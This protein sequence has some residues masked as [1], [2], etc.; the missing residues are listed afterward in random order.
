MKK[1]LLNAAVV[2]ALGLSITACEKDE[3]RVVI[4]PSAMPALTVSNNA[5]GALTRANANDPGVTFSWSPAEFGY[6]AAVTYSLEIDKA[7]NNFASPRVFPMGNDRSKAFTKGELNQIYNDLDC[8][9]P[10]APPATALQAR[11]RASVGDKFA[12]SMSQVLTVTATPFQAQVA[13]ADSWGI[14]GDA[15]VNGWNSDADLTYDFCS[16]T[17]KISNFRLDAAGA[18][19][20]R[21][22]DAWTNNLGGTAAAT[23]NTASPVLTAGGANIAVPAGTGNYDISLNMTTKTFTWVKRP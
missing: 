14:I 18:F 7:G 17:Y 11:V 2:C 16:G 4:N 22:N 21:A 5:P 8:N 10:A 23:P 1:W 6:Q 13:P 15:T 3:N 9:L 20:F 12:P 19:K